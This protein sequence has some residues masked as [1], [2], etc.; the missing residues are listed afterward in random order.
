MN[1]DVCHTPGKPH[2]PQTH[3][4]PL[5]QQQPPHRPTSKLFPD[6]HCVSHLLL[7]LLQQVPK[8]QLHG[9]Y[10]LSAPNRA[11]AAACPTADN[12]VA[13]AAGSFVVI[14]DASADQQVQLLRST[15]SNQTL[16]CLAWSCCGTHVAAGEAGNNPAVV[17]WNASS[18]AC[19]RELKGHKHTVN[20]LCFS[21]DGEDKLCFS[22]QV[23]LPSV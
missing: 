6:L 14:S 9:V 11:V 7:L 18:G 5:Q 13:T 17:V 4:Q 10:G 2:T 19:V 3:I 15:T 23:Q 1:V 12:L 21:P 8:L 16:Q 20:R 22:E